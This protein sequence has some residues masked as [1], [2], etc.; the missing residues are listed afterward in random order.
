MNNDNLGFILFMCMFVGACFGFILWN[1]DQRVKR[2]METDWCFQ[3]KV[4]GS[5]YHYECEKDVKN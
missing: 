4:D 2:A 3:E 1:S 5:F